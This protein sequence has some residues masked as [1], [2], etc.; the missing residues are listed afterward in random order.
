VDHPKE[1][2]GTAVLGQDRRT[3]DVE[4]DF[5]LRGQLTQLVRT[6]RVERRPRREEA[7]DLAQR[8]VQRSPLVVGLDMSRRTD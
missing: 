3:R 6:E 8:R 1:G 4:L 2:D 7:R 5:G